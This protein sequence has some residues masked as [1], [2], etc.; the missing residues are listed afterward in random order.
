[1]GNC[2]ISARANGSKPASK[3]LS[4]YFEYCQAMLFF[5]SGISALREAFL[6]TFVLPR[7]IPRIKMETSGFLGRADF[8]F[9][10]WITHSLLPG[11]KNRPI[12]TVRPTDGFASAFRIWA[13]IFFSSALALHANDARK[14]V[15]PS[16]AGIGDLL[17]LRSS[18]GLRTASANSM[19]RAAKPTFTGRHRSGQKLAG[20]VAQWL[21]ILCG[22]EANRV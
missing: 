2:D 22:W 15:N 14:A 16:L 13:V 9:L 18:K 11:V 8:S 19:M 10:T 1:M 7:R 5:K 17:I 20:Y 6:D 3:L 4:S 12:A 21:P